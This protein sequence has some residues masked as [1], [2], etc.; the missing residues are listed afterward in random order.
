MLRDVEAIIFDMDGTIIDSMWVWKKVDVDFLQKRNIDV[1]YNIQHQIEGLSFTET[2]VYFKNKFSLKEDVEEIKHEW[3]DMVRHYYEN[4]IPLKDGALSFILW[5]KK[6]KLKIGLA[7]SNSR[8]LTEIILKRTGIYDYFDFTATS[9][10]VPKDKSFPDI[11]L[12]V[13]E[14]LDVPP[15]KCLVFEDTL[16]SI[17][18]AKKAGMKVVAVFDEYSLPYKD[19]ITKSADKY[20][21]NFQEIA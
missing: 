10:E 14:K 6:N 12:H 16:A 7:T 13:A 2:A 5:L 20:I 21:M 4:I 1:P 15:S 11:F 9:C 19:E 18:G 8:E 17:Q 3:S